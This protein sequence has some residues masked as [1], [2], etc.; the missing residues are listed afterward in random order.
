MNYLKKP[1][2]NLSPY[3]IFI[4]RNF[5]KS[6]IG[7]L[8][9]SSEKFYPDFIIWIKTQSNTF[10]QAIVFADP[11]SGYFPFQEKL[12]LSISIKNIQ[13]E[14]SNRYKVKIILESFIIITNPNICPNPSKNLINLS[15]INLIFK[16]I[17][18]QF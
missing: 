11:K 4:Y 2:I 18:D 3:E 14:I 5:P 7:F 6:G 10:P 9:E 17:I 13:S 12:D 8:L 1:D 15:Q 16:K